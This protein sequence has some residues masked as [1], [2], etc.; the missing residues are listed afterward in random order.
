MNTT[1]M[2]H[3]VSDIAHAIAERYAHL[4]AGEKLS[5]SQGLGDLQPT[6]N[7]ENLSTEM[8]GVLAGCRML[9]FVEH[10][11]QCIM[12]A[13]DKQS[14]RLGAFDIALWPTNVSDFGMSPFPRHNAF[15]TCPMKLGLYVVL[16]NS[17][18]VARMAQAGIPAVQL[19][20]KSD[21]K[22]AVGKEVAASVAAT[23][24]TNTLLFINDHWEEAI[25]VGAYGVHLGQEDMQEAPLDKIRSAGLRLGLS[26]HGYKEMLL[27][28]SH[29]PS[30]IALGAVFPTT[31]KRMVTEP[32]GLG[33]LERYAQLMQNYPL[34]AIGGIDLERLPA[35]VKTGV[36][37]VAVVRAITESE[38]PEATAIAFQR[39]IRP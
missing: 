23:Q 8:Q 7:L 25:A 11:A 15:A 27:A 17:Q 3:S 38:S 29:S 28:D 14:A 16:P 31:L 12:Q 13:W 9:G 18:W 1:N 30:Y 34:V 10:D 6:A 33:R 32:Q 21:D 26:T 5:F 19:R 2:H 39:A 24:G 22:A 36:G 4:Q 37:S 20:F 35:V